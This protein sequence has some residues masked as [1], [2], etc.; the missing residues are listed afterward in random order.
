MAREF[1]AAGDSVVICGRDAGS[2][3]AA[4]AALAAEHGDGRVHGTACDVSSPADM[5]RFGD[6]AAERLGGVD[7]WLNNAG[8]G[9]RGCWFALRGGRRC[10]HR[11]L[12]LACHAGTWSALLGGS[13]PAAA[14]RS[15]RLL[16]SPSC[17][18]L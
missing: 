16:L 18:L 11:T 15:L 10:G 7:L 8:E 3:A 9:G 6:L 13:S 14:C 4:V 1:L 17:L 12:S 5:Q 2:V